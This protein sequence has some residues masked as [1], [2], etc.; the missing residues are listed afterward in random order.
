MSLF[1]VES[2]PLI[3]EISRREPNTYVFFLKSNRSILIRTS[4][5]SIMVC[6][7]DPSKL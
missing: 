6:K 7:S 3:D 4:Q 5:K 2:V 1:Y